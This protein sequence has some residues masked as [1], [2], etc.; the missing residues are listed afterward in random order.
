[1]ANSESRWREIFG[2]TKVLLVASHNYPHVR[3]ASLKLADVGTGE[4]V[5][6]LCKKFGC[7]GLISTKI[8]SD[9]NWYVD[10]PFR[11]MAKEIIDTR[12]IEIVLDIHGRNLDCENLIEF[13]PNDSFGKKK[14]FEGLVVK[15]FVD[16]EQLTLI[17]DLDNHGISGVEV[18]IRKD[19]RVIMIDE[20]NYYEVQRI[21][22]EVLSELV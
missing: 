13:F 9:P 18:E 7:W 15:E 22:S 19:G 4:V 11:E 1:M 17:E 2:V 3:G 16:D 10:S 5:E 21:L 8:Q 14:C 20:D 12:Q 6:S